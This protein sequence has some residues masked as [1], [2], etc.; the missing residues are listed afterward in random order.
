MRDF[1]TQTAIGLRYRTDELPPIGN[2][3]WKQNTLDPPRAFEGESFESVEY[4]D[5]VHTEV[6]E[7]SEGPWFISFSSFVDLDSSSLR[8]ADVDTFLTSV[9]SEAFERVP[10]GS[11]TMSTFRFYDVLTNRKSR[12]LVEEIAN[13]FSL[14]NHIAL[15]PGYPNAFSEGLDLVIAENGEPA[16]KAIQDLILSERVKS[17]IAMEALQYVGDAESR[18]WLNARRNMLE[19]CLRESNSSWVR[20]GAGL[21]IASLNDVRSIGAIKE[22]I[23]KEPSD[24]LKEDLNLV[25]RQL[26]NISPDEQ[27]Q[28]SISFVK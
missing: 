7:R 6:A 14:A 12:Q 11:K 10:V 26:Q 24:A 4:A 19:M 2:I 5:P 17:S 20:D 13:L 21:G 28:W 16:L 23:Q 27:F 18:T 3:S 15:E 1:G 22:A 9:I 8:V 25:L